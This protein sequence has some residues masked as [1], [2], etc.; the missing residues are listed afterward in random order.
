MPACPTWST[1]TPAYLQQHIQDATGK[2]LQPSITGVGSVMGGAD[3]II[4]ALTATIAGLVSSNPVVSTVDGLIAE[5]SALQA[6]GS[7]AV[8]AEMQPVIQ[9]LIDS[10]T[11]GNPIVGQVADMRSQLAG[12][13][14]AAGPALSFLGP[15]QRIP[16]RLSRSLSLTP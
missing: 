5:L 12:L 16:Q 11:A 9:G 6:S 15:Q 7:P 4:A 3:T 14:S 2:F 13:V 8:V 10:A 1:A